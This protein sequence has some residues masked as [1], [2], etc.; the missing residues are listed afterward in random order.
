MPRSRKPVPLPLEKVQVGDVFALPL[1]DGRYGACRVLRRRDDPPGV[2]VAASPWVGAAPPDLAEPLLRTI[3]TQSHHHWQDEPCVYWVND[4]VPAEF[5]ALGR[6]PPA[7]KEAARSTN[8]ADW[9]SFGYQIHAQWRWDHERE[10]VLA[11]EEA[12]RQRQQEAQEAS[13]RAYK[14]LPVEGIE[15]VRKRPFKGWETFVDSDQLRAARRLV[16]KTIDALLA[17]GP[18]AAAPLKINL[19]HALIEQ[20]NEIDDGWICTIEREDICELADD[21]ADRVG[22]EEYGEALTGRRDW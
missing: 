6:L 15:E 5:L 11:E 13:R 9:V 20:F 10:A 19:F 3:L 22:L 2:L 14:P 4:P 16:R 12:A 8:S 1:P 7:K 21:L 18:D 17:L